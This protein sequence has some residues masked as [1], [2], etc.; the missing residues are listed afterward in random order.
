MQNQTVLR[1]AID[2]SAGT[3]TATLMISSVGGHDYVDSG[4]RRR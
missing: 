3:Y 1:R 2:V 4:S